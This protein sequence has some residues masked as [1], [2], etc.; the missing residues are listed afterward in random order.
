MDTYNF[1]EDCAYKKQY[2]SVLNDFIQ[3]CKNVQEELHNLGTMSSTLN[4]SA[5]GLVA[6]T[7]KT[8][9]TLYLYDAMALKFK[10]VANTWEI[11]SFTTGFV[12]FAGRKDSRIWPEQQKNNTGFNIDVEYCN[13]PED[14]YFQYSTVYD[15]VERD[16]CINMLENFHELDLNSGL[17]VIHPI[18][19]KEEILDNINNLYTRYT[20][21]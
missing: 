11:N 16:I 21:E 5:D 13:I 17:V 3:R 10:S 9:T 19:F 18:F 14:E 7:N 20:D 15:I 12:Y 6:T 1:Y 2:F 4:A 8:D